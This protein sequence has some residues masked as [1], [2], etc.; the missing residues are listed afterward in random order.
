MI[1]MKTHLGRHFLFLATFLATTFAG[2][3]LLA[4]FI[5]SFIDRSQFRFSILYRGDVVADVAIFGDSR[6]VHS[7]YAPSVNESLGLKAFNFGYNGFSTEMIECL[8]ADYVTTCP[9]PKFIVL[10]V[11]N[12]VRPPAALGNL[13]P[14]LRHSKLLTELFHR[15]RPEEYWST[16]LSHLFRLNCELT[17]RVLYFSQQSDQ[18]WILNR[19]ISPELPSYDKLPD[20]DGESIDS[21]YTEKNFAALQR[22][23]QLANDNGIELR[24]VIA[25]YWPD[26]YKHAG[27]RQAA[28]AQIGE[29]LRQDTRNPSS[30]SIW[31]Y[32][33]LLDEPKYFADPVH[34]NRAG[35]EQL[36]LRMKADGLF[37]AGRRPPHN[38][39]QILG[40]PAIQSSPDQI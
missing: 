9:P 24:L 15:E 35:A 40:Q 6:G 33:L 8:V 19:S 32:S 25:P 20:V 29:R 34:T 16:Q 17:M 18:G 27:K 13:K 30:V 26:F 4:T 38:A 37:E 39:R 28:L 2:D 7:F 10:E 21:E 23:V 14:F 11:T 12:V 31:D 5:G 36:I 1:A 3:R 22:I